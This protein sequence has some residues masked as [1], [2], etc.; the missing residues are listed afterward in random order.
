MPDLTSRAEEALL[1]ALITDPAQLASVPSLTPADF[2]DPARQAVFNA[3]S[4][5]HDQVPDA[6][7]AEFAGRIAATA[8]SA[9]V[10]VGYLDQITQA[11]PTP[12]AAAVYGRMVIEAAFDR[13]L[14]AHAAE[15]HAAA[16]ASDEPGEAAAVA[17][18]TSALTGNLQAARV[19]AGEA[20]DR[21]AAPGDP[22][23]V[24]EERFL[25][26]LMRQPTI[27]DWI[28]VDPQVFT[29]P[30]RREVYEA[31]VAID[32]HGEPVDE[33]TLTWALARDA[34]ISHSA[35][36]RIASPDALAAAIPSGMVA[37]LAATPIDT[38]VGVEAA[39]DL[40]AA[41]AQAQIAEATGITLGPG[42]DGITTPAARPAA[43]QHG[44][45][46]EPLLA[47]PPDRE[48]GRDTPQLHHE[49]S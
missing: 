33:L 47:R 2:T 32:Q 15:A 40:L 48:L 21:A 4:A 31:I 26:A 20:P 13:Q 10:T 44:L 25:A 14:G 43:R 12:N 1:G 38:A 46:S 5:V 42:Q 24:L 22:Q 29:S 39:R 16:I 18:I 11:T 8:G 9:R 23:E 28:T 27:T 17:G 45:G 36:A 41:R 35:T 3:I 49:G 30:A 6:R 37:R 19:A 7:G 34:A